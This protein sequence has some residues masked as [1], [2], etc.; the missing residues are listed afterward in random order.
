MQRYL[1]FCC[2]H[3]NKIVR[4]KNYFLFFAAFFMAAF[5][6]CSKN[7]PGGYVN[8]TLVGKWVLTK[9][10]VCNSCIDTIPVNETETLVFSSNGQVQVFGWVGNIEQHF[11]GTYSVAQQPYGK[12]LN[13]HPDAA[14]SGK[15]F[16]YI[17]GSVI[18]SET[19]T[20][21]VLDLNTPFS[22]PCLY[23]NTYTAVPG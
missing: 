20:T 2:Q 14:D 10:C 12:V 16:L 19:G 23:Q 22:N 5:F 8:P 6:S 1:R 18:Y 4:M 3:I 13:I 11:S 17:P 7:T 21:L 9:I 15:Y